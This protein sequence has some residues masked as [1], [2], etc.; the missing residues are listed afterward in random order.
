MSWLRPLLRSNPS[1]PEILSGRPDIPF[2]HLACELMSGFF[3]QPSGPG[4][5]RLLGQIPVW[6]WR[7]TSSQ[8][9]AALNQPL[10]L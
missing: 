3:R 4:N 7:V 8:R 9:R 2:I 5:V 6:A 10:A 1:P